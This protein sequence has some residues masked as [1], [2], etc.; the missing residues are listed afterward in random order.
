[1]ILNGEIVTKLDP[2]TSDDYMNRFCSNLGLDR[3]IQNVSRKIAE[4]AFDLDLVPGRVPISVAAAAIYMASQTSID[5]KSLH[6]ISEITGVAESTIKNSYRQMRERAIE[7]F[8]E[9]FSGSFYATSIE[10][11]PHH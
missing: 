5:K 6:E 3:K 7:L 2:T 4:R 10:Q 8:P 9:N 1:L 11:L